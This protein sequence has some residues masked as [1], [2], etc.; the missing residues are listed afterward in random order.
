MSYICRD[1]SA[2]TTPCA[3]E[4]AHRRTTPANLRCRHKGRWEHYMV[5]DSVW[6]AAGMPAMRGIQPLGASGFLC[7]GCLERRLG[8]EL[9]PRDFRPG[10]LLSEPSPWDTERLA[11]RKRR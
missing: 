3:G 6:K 2:D 9:K 8:R 10:V 5:R 4:D 1:C 7:I 11:R